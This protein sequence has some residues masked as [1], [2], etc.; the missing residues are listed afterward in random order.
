MALFSV[1]TASATTLEVGGVA[2]NSSVAVAM[3]LASGT[4]L[5]IKD[6]FGTTTDTCTS[7]ETSFS[8]ESPF[9]ATEVS[10]TVQSWTFANCS[11]PTIVIKKGWAIQKVLSGTRSDYFSLLAEVTIQSTFFGASAICKT[12]LGTTWGEYTGVSSGKGKVDIK[13]YLDCGILGTASWTG[14]YTVTSPEGL[15]VVN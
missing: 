11:H 9:T 4:S 7:S 1:G 3:S 14:T 13:G 8:T 2:K 10:G 15:G 12:G 5:I 6:E